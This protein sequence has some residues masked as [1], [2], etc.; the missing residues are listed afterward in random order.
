M[1]RNVPTAPLPEQDRASTGIAGLDHVLGGVT[2]YG[3]EREDR[4]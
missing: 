1:R 3:G 4:S 2:V